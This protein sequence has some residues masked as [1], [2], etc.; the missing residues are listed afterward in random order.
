MTEFEH[1]SE[2]FSLFI[3][4]TTTERQKQRM[5]R[6]CKSR[7]LLNARISIVFT[8]IPDFSIQHSVLSN[9]KENVY[10]NEFRLPRKYPVCQKRI[11]M[12]NEQIQN[13]YAHSTEF[14]LPAGMS[15]KG[16]PSIVIR[17][18]IKSRAIGCAHLPNLSITC[19]IRINARSTSCMRINER[20][21]NKIAIKSINLWCD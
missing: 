20:R 19:V 2:A 10:F 18:E 3:Y 9:V 4:T 15:C 5:E 6:K 14:G 8:R 7:N 13:D 21:A 1:K 11:E 12:R 16:M 17:S